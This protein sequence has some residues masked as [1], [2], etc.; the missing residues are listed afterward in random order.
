[1]R[2]PL[3]YESQFEL[4]KASLTALA[5]R[6]ALDRRGDAIAEAEKISKER[7][8]KMVVDTFEPGHFGWSDYQLPVGTHMISLKDNVVF[9][10]VG[11]WSIDEDFTEIEWWEG[12]MTK[13]LDTWQTYMVAKTLEKSMEMYP[14]PR[15]AT[16]FTMIVKS[17]P[18]KAAVDAWLIAYVVYP[19]TMREMSIIH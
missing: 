14:Q 10:P 15:F 2:F 1:M 7:G 12:G 4:D 11:I 5:H 19:E 8:I 17:S 13:F 16:S 18:P 3:L 9:Y 6:L